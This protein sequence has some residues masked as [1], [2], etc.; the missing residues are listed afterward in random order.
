MQVDRLADAVLHG[1]DQYVHGS[2]R[3]REHRRFLVG[4]SG[5]PGAGKSTLAHDVARRIN[6]RRGAEVCLCVGMDGWHYSRR[7]LDAMPDPAHAHA[8]RGAAFTFDAEAFVAWVERLRAAAPGAFPRCTAPTFSHAEKDPVPDGLAIEPWHTIVL[9]EGLYCNLDVA[10]WDR[11]AACWDLR[12][13]V[14]VTDAEARAR[15]TRRHLEAG[16][17]PTAEAAQ[18]R[19]DTNDLPNG[20]WILAHTIEPIERLG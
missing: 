6:E 18:H 2:H 8:R 7:Q 5:I 11:A 20:A 1:A 12:W 9:V 16:L 17:A 19:A 14:Q 4:I 3:L 10:P 15:L 13:F